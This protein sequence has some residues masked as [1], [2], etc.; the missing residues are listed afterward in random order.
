MLLET[1]ENIN[2]TQAS[3]PKIEICMLLSYCFLMQYIIKVQIRDEI[4]V[5]SAF[6]I[7]MD[8]GS[9]CNLF[10]TISQHLFYS[11]CVNL[12]M[13]YYEFCSSSPLRFFLASLNHTLAACC[14]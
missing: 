12:I 7:R 3:G 13:V 2:C 10:I 6:Y 1:R 9:V 14:C 11:Y 4:F 8:M 5:E